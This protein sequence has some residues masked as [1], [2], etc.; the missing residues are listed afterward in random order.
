MARID[1]AADALKTLAKHSEVILDAYMNQGG[2][3]LDLEENRPAIKALIKHSLAW[4]MDP[5]EPVRLSQSLS[6][7][8]AAVTRSQLRYSANSAVADL[9][10]EIDDAIEGYREA[11]NRGAL[12]DSEHYLSNAFFFGHQLIESLKDSLAVF[13]HHLNS[14]FTHIQNLDLRAIE[15][16]K[17]IERASEFNTILESFDYQELYNKAGTDTDLRRLLLKLI[18]RALEECRKQLSYSIERLV[19]MLHTINH[20]Q[21][22]A[23][24][25]DSILTLFDREEAYLP[26]VDDLMGLPAVLNIAPKLAGSVYADLTNPEHEASLASIV[27]S[28]PALNPTEKESFTPEPI[29]NALEGEVIELITDPT[30]VAIQETLALLEMTDSKISAKAVYELKML[31]Q[32]CDLELWYMTLVNEV[33]GL[34]YQERSKIHLKFIESQDSTFNGNYWVS[35][36]ILQGRTVSHEARV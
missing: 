35:D 22:K 4:Q 20:Q 1:D 28:L 7:L 26:N 5:D 15:N 6:K 21:H 23:R 3:L 30:R 10:K 19:N 27:E 29:K 14:E 36:V 13:A 32:S 33:Q 24:L 17:M 16:R 11:K 18:P 12:E 31:Q 25:V 8:L 2:A 34:P 9:W